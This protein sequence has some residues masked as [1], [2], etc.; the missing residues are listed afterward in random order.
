MGVSPEQMRRLARGAVFAFVI[1]TA[2]ALLFAGQLY[3]SRALQGRPVPW[4]HALGA[5]LADWYVF[6]FLAPPAAWLGRRVRIEWPLRAKPVITHVSAC[7]AFMMAYLVCRTLVALWQARWGGGWVSYYEMFERALVHTLPH[8]LL[9][10][11]ALVA[12]QHVVAYQER[13]RERERRAVELEQRLTAARLQALQMQL[14]PHVLF[15]TLN[16]IS[17]LMHKDV[18]AADR[19]LVRLSELLRRALDTRDR[20]E[21]PLHE[22]LTFLD[23]Y[24]EIERTR[25]GARLEIE[26]QIDATALNAMV[27]NLLLQPLVENAIK[28]GIEGQR[29]GRLWLDV[30]REGGELVLLVRDNGPGPKPER[31]QSRGH[32]IG[33]SN[34]RRRL[35]QLY[36]SRQKLVM[37]SAEGGGTEVMVRMPWRAREGEGLVLAAKGAKS[38]KLQEEGKG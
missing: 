12:T 34:T 17:S 28:H 13:A 23:R 16:A 31:D 25:F 30:H 29:R 9:V 26:R 1:W 27:P 8:S 18:E 32:G 3:A 7:A 33:L 4:T 19:M 20:Q 22:E 21:V 14:N 36:G 15:N 37:R 10:Y 6:A 38:A 5:A 2:L 24:L 11:C 35:E